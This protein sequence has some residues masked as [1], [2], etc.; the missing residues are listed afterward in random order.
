MTSVFIRRGKLG[1]RQ[2]ERMLREDGGRDWTDVSTNQGTL[3]FASNHQKLARGKDKSSHRGFIEI[4]A[5][6][7][8]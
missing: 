5:L 8:P 1:H 6:L 2:T 7:T 4:V 3:K